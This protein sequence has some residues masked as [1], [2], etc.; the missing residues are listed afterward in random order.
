MRAIVLTVTFLAAAGLLS[1]SS[2]A[3]VSE[4]EINSLVNQLS[5]KSVGGECNGYWRIVPQ[6]DAAKR[7]IEIGKPAT[8][9][10]VQ[11]LTDEERGVAAHL[12]LT[13][14]WEAESFSYQNRIEVDPDE[15]AYFIHVYNGLRWTDVIELKVPS[16]SSRVDP[17]DLAAN[18]RRWKRK[19]R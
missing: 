12:V 16:L 10:L 17:V 11:V 15:V 7:L 2:H 13:A 14:I 6:G 3:Q 8:S 19:T 5:W 9:K 18:A 4:H 1:T